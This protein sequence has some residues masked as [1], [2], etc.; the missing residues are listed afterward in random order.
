MGIGDSL[1]RGWYRPGS[2]DEEKIAKDPLPANREPGRASS[3][4]AIPV[5][6][7]RPVWREFDVGKIGGTAHRGPSAGEP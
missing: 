7:A 3:A 6:Q 1:R 2:A 4:M 5:G